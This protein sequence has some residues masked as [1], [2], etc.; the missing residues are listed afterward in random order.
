MSM[1]PGSGAQRK[2]CR[3]E[4]LR[5]DGEELTHGRSGVDSRRGRAG[6]QLRRCAPPAQ[7]RGGHSAIRIR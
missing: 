7:L 6:E 5:L 4:I 3:A 1:F 2:P